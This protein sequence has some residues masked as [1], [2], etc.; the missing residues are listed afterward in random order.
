MIAA[1]SALMG[2]A[3]RTFVNTI[4]GVQVTAQ[5]AS[6][7]EALRVL[8]DSRPHLLVVDADLAEGDLSAC[9]QSLL[10]LAPDLCIIALVNNHRQRTAALGAGAAHALLKGNL[11]EQLRQ[12]IMPDQF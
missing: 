6:R 12:A 4:N 5:A 3:L 11:N 7:A 1:P 9:L 8:A 10:H 2:S